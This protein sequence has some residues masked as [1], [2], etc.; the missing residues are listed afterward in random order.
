[1]Y[2]SECWQ[3]INKEIGEGVGYKRKGWRL[4]GDIKACDVNTNMVKDREKYSTSFLEVSFQSI[5]SK[6]NYVLQI[7]KNHLLIV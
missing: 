5:Y 7:L 3:L 6:K 1:M 4:L 2:G